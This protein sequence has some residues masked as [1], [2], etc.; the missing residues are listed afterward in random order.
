[1]TS[2]VRARVWLLSCLLGG[3]VLSACDDTPKGTPDAGVEPGAWDGGATPLEEHGNWSDRGPYAPCALREHGTP[4]RC[5]SLGLGS[6]DLTAC[7]SDALS[8]VPQEGIY[9][10]GQRYESRLADGGTQV[11]FG[12]GIGFKLDGAGGGTLASRPLITRQTEGG[13][14]FITSGS[15]TGTAVSR[16]YAGC[17][18]P[19]PETLTG[20]YVT[21]NL[22]GTVSQSG[23][24]EAHRMTWPVGEPESSG[25]LTLVSESRVLLG[26]PVDIYVTR[27]HAYVVSVSDSLTEQPGGLTVFDVTDKAHPVLK[28]SISLPGDNYWNGVW[29]KGDALY[30]AS[31]VAGV[32]VYDISKPAE[33]VFVRGLWAG[34]YGVHTVLVEGERLY[35]T[36]NEGRTEI[37][38]LTQPLEPVLLQSI[39]LSEELSAGGPHDTFVY[40]GR[41]YISNAQGGYSIMDITRLDDVKHLGQYSYPDVY[42]H[43]SAVGTFAGRTIAFEGGEFA[44]SHLR[45]LDVTD[46]AHIIKI[47]EHRLRPVSS[48]HNMILKGTRL[49]IAWYQ[50]GVRVLDVANPTQPRQVAH[51]NVFREEDATRTDSI[52]QGAFGIR[53]PGDGFIYV[54]ESARGLLIFNEL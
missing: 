6:F 39:S 17:Q 14:F 30:I 1:M 46:P 40:E 27:N 9:Q 2:L 34:D 20:C 31:D 26:R 51:Y 43:H 11:M 7:D 4:L 23:T 19:T 13:T 44:G 21:C 24:F 32:I 41:L 35:A 50:E 5:D 54:V 22:A 3:S 18:R 33:P 12:V 53:L 45:V 49:Y 10:A 8:L 28:T 25:G 29:S 36:S 38:D 16:L 37:Y 52:F 15:R 42:S 47:G 48:I